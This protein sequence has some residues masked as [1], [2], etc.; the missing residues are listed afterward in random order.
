MNSN[1]K[2]NF[3]PKNF[4]YKIYLLVFLFLVDIILNSFTQFLSFGS[5]AAI[6]EYGLVNIKVQAKYISFIILII[7]IVLQFIMFFT[8]LSLFYNTFYFSMGMIKE[9]CNEFLLT[10]IVLGLYP[11]IFIAERIIRLI[12]LRKAD[13]DIHRNVISIWSNILYLVIYILK[14]VIGVFYYIFV[15]NAS[16]ELGK[17][18]YYKPD[19]D[20]M[21]KLRLE[22]L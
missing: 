16:Y 10:F 8:T 5:Q 11:L 12:Y 15:L 21:K 19:E 2:N 20:L 7:H 18:K 4:K 14:Y 17:S 9:I 6:L 13:T 22:K 1:V 3:K